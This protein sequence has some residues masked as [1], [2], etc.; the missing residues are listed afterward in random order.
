MINGDTETGITTF[1]L[2]HEIDTGEVI[3]QV[4][5]PIADTDDVGIVHDKLMLLGGRL[6]V[7]TVDAIL[8]GTVKS[9]PQEEMAVVGELRPAP[10]I[11]KDT[12]RIDWN[13]PVKRIYDFVRGLS[14]YPAAWTEL[15]QPGGESVVV[16][17]F[18]TE[19][20][21]ES[22]QLAPGTLQ[23]DGKTYIRVTAED[24]FVGIRSLQLPGKKKLKTDEL[25]RGFRLTEGY[26]MK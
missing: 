17:I 1:F 11:F 21:G 25:L 7:E 10:K 16:K 23:T 9:I 3:Q 8:A 22:H 2:K 19:K 12:C 18:E 13:R 24:G 6:V 15:V 20:I 14:P 4:R 5:V 26:V